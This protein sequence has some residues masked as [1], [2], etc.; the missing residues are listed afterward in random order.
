MQIRTRGTIGGSIAHCRPG[1]RAAR[2]RPGAG[3]AAAQNRPPR[4][5]QRSGLRFLPRV[6][7]YRPRAGRT[8][9]PHR[10]P[11][12][13]AETGTS[14]AEVSRRR[15]D[16]AL[17]AAAAVITV[18]DNRVADARLALAGVTPCPVRMA[19]A[20][21]MLRGAEATAD[22]VQSAARAAAGTLT[23]QADVHGSAS[24]RRRLGA[25]TRQQDAH[26]RPGKER[27]LT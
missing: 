27:E 2:R 15:D 13:P 24:Y 26:Y 4:R 12:L 25:R 11:R 9:R 7:C 8:A 16:F 6:L 21:S 5:T 19:A 14:F 22:I 17:V 18:R 1:R 3:Y 23:P 20:D 10:L